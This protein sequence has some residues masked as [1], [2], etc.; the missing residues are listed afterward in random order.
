ML[1]TARR[2]STYLSRQGVQGT[3]EFAE[4]LAG[5]EG[6]GALLRVPL[7]VAWGTR[8]HSSSHDTFTAAHN[9]GGTRSPRPSLAGFVALRWRKTTASPLALRVGPTL[10]VWQ[11]R[12]ETNQEQD[13]RSRRE[14]GGRTSAR[15]D[16]LF[17]DVSRGSLW[18]R[19]LPWL[20]DAPCE[21]WLRIESRY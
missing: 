12:T 7:A 13:S 6:A 5:K 11:T 17:G 9:R 4:H 14:C 20:L 3:K 15:R 18:L 8:L 16:P 10:S 19:S 2:T 1:P 21:C